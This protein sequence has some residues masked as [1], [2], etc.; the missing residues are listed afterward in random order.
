[1][2]VTKW[3]DKSKEGRPALLEVGLGAG[4]ARGRVRRG[5]RWVVVEAERVRARDAR[6]R[7][8]GPPGLVARER[9]ERGHEEGPDDEGVVED[10][11]EEDK[12]RLV[13]DGRL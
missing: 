3:E 1:M 12:G 11:D 13:E 7:G 9:E 6:G 10:R 5:V 4:R 8:R 2:S